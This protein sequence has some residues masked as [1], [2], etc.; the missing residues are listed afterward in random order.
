MPGYIDQ[1]LRVSTQE[2]T[3]GFSLGTQEAVGR[4]IAKEK[5]LKVRL[6]NE[7]VGSSIRQYRPVLE[8]LK[9]N[10]DGG[11]LKHPWIHTRSRLYRSVAGSFFRKDYLDK[12]NVSLTKSISDMRSIST[13]WKNGSS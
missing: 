1:Y 13:P 7:G 2:Q 4:E 12:Y 6:R 9:D 5:G 10:I 11:Y 8:G 3:K